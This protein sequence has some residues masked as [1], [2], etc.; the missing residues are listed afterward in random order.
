MSTADCTPP[1]CPARALWLPTYTHH[2][3]HP[4]TDASKVTDLNTL[5]F[6][7]DVTGADESSA[8]GLESE[9]Y[10]HV[11]SGQ[12]E[13]V[14]HGG[15]AERFAD[16]PPAPVHDDI[17]LAKLKPGQSIVLEAHAVKGE[18][19]DHAKFSPVATA[20]YRLMPHVELKQA[21]TGPDAAELAALS[22]VFEV[23]TRADGVKEAVVAN[24]RVCNMSREILRDPKW[25]R[26]VELSRV[27][28]HFICT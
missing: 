17:V 21:V 27:N 7:L 3:H 19:H 9:R 23:R 20:S 13:W 6:R 18:G 25:G 16:Q 26:I 15:Q 14:P 4:P 5:V 10:T 2:H 1:A 12:L 11:Y 8:N 24:P 28:D 22:P